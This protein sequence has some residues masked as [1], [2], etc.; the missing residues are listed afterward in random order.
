MN[1]HTLHTWRLHAKGVSL[2]LQGRLL[3]DPQRTLRGRCQVLTAQVQRLQL[4]AA[5]HRLPAHTAPAELSS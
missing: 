4:R 3:R 5:A 1:P 2:M